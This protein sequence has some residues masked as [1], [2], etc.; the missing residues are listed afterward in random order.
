VARQAYGVVEDS[1]FF[2]ITQLQKTVDFPTWLGAYEKALDNGANETRAIELADQ[3]VLDSQGGGQI[4]DLASIQRGSQLM[5]IWTNFYSY[6]NTTFNLTVEAFGKTNFRDPVSIG[7]LAVDVLML[8]TV[9]AVLTVAL[10]EAVNLAI[11]GDEPDE[12]ELIDKLIQEQL[13][14]AMGTMVGLREFATIFDP[15]FSYSGPAGA[16]FIAEVERLG[17]QISQGELDEGLRK[18]VVNTAGILLHFPSGQVN[19]IIDGIN[20]LEEGKS[21]SPAALIFGPPKD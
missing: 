8:Y 4:K 5:K 12:E 16:R 14:Y 3:A 2:L 13:T 11:G 20:A 15:R 10:R 21:E 17:N 9:P 18:A 6:F 7:R 1:F 19:R